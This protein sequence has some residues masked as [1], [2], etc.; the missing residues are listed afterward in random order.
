MVT[1]HT[2]ASAICVI[3]KNSYAATRIDLIESGMRRTI[4]TVAY[5]ECGRIDQGRA[6]QNDVESAA[7]DQSAVPVLL[8]EIPRQ[9]TPSY[10]YIRPVI[11]V[12]TVI[13]PTFS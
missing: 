3:R 4:D 10:P 13:S 1:K 9:M 12:A 5:I 2:K 11:R 7:H 8:G 6:R